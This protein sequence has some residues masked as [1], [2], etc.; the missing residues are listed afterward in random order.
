MHSIDDQ[1]NIFFPAYSVQ[2]FSL[3][4][5]LAQSINLAV[6][7]NYPGRHNII[8]HLSRDGHTTNPLARLNICSTSVI[9]YSSLP[10]L[11]QILLIQK[12]C[13][14]FFLLYILPTTA[15]LIP[16]KMA[17]FLFCLP[18]L[19]SLRIQT[20]RCVVCLCEWLS[21]INQPGRC[22]PIEDTLFICSSGRERW[23]ERAN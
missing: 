21:P 18:V 1:F 16:Q 9:E 4:T 14:F 13:T 5:D 10:E 15:I 3:K 8:N 11:N 12:S 2:Q 6:S 17:L 22:S 7:C 23:S 19:L 20:K